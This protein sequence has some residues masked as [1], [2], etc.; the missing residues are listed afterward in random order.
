M[1]TKEIEVM[2][3][4]CG[5]SAHTGF[6][7]ITDDPDFVPFPQKEVFIPVNPRHQELVK[8][9]IPAI[10]ITNIWSTI[11][12]FAAYNTRYYTTTTGV[13]AV[14]WLEQ[15]YKNIAGSRLG[16]DIIVERF[17]HSWAQ[18]SLII[19]II[20]TK[21]PQQRVIIGGHVD[22]TAGGANARSPGADDDASGTATVLEVFRVL[23]SSSTYKPE[24]TLEF[25]GYA[26]EEAGL[27][28]S[29][30]IARSYRSRGFTVSGMLQLDMT[31]Y[32]GSSRSMGLVTDNTNQALTRFVD[33]CIRA[34]CS[35][36]PVSTQCGYGCSDHAS[37]TSNGFPAAFTFESTFSSSN[38][39]I[40]TASDTLNR[41]TATHAVEFAK[42]ALAFQIEMGF[43]ETSS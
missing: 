39:Y 16:K 13:Q 25:H 42:L 14:T 15:Q 22:S 17:D 30:A 4:E 2:I 28:G 3:D 32:I 20:G 33:L 35:I 38:P 11:T 6:I 40:H 31:G 24:R 43:G 12:S 27:L 8:S 10:S 7:D 36:P 23:A 21:F 34:Y 5:R 41:L 19:S 18:P 26:A 9:L 1:S 37:W 29:S